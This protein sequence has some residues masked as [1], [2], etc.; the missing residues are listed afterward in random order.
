MTRTVPRQLFFRYILTGGAAALVD[1]GGFAMLLQ[2]PV[3]IALAGTASFAL[4]VL[5]NYTLTSRFVFQVQP[6]LQR[7]PAFALGALAGLCINMGGT[8]G[9]SAL[10]FAPV[11]AKCAGIGMAFLFNYAINAAVIF[12]R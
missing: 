2:F 12:R 9:L 7:L 11:L 4:A 5:V 6:G 10:G 1:L 8:L 3:P